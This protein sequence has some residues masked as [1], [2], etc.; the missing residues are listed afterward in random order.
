MICERGVYNT[1]NASIIPHDEHLMVSIWVTASQSGHYR[2]YI[3]GVR[4]VLLMTT[5]IQNWYNIKADDVETGRTFGIIPWVKALG[6]W[7][8]H[9]RLMNVHEISKTE[10][11]RNKICQRWCWQ[12]AR[13]DDKVGLR[14]N[15]KLLAVYS[16]PHSVDLSSWSE[17]YLLSRSST[18]THFVT[19]SYEDVIANPCGSRH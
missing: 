14:C 3:L 2:T 10:I 8:S 5:M 11:S 6:Q 1:Y 18:R 13:A 12:Q 17:A 4:S 15:L 19:D 16:P 9:R 7:I